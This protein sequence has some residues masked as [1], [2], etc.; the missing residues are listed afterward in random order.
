MSE[1]SHHGNVM[2]DRL[3]ERADPLRELVVAGEA[4]PHARVPLTPVGLRCLTPF[5]ASEFGERMA[6]P[7][8]S[9]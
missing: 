6:R 8:T 5:I 4:F 3:S 9:S 2:R 7:K 1:L